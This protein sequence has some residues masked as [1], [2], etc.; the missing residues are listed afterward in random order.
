MCEREID[1][2]DSALG[3]GV[4]PRLPRRAREVRP[5]ARHL[6]KGLGFRVWG[7]ALGLGVSGLGVE[8]LGFRISD[9]VFRGSDFVF[10]V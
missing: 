9:F 6:V 4:M 10:R 5:G 3:G 8:G 2:H 1:L 7:S